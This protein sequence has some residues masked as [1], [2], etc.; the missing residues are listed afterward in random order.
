MT[1]AIPVPLTTFSLV[2][3][4]V[5]LALP[6]GRAASS[7]GVLEVDR[8]DDE[9]NATACTPAPDDCSFRGAAINANQTPGANTIEMPAGI[10]TL[11]ISGPDEDA[12]ANSDID[13]TDD[14]ALK[15]AGIGKT[16]IDGGLLDTVLQIDANFDGATA[17]IEDLTIRNGRAGVRTSGDLTLERTEITG[18]Q[19][20]GL[21]VESAVVSIVDSTISGNGTIDSTNGGGVY[22]TGQ[23]ILTIEDSVI[24]GNSAT[25]G[26]A[27]YLTTPL[28]SSL[29]VSNTT[30]SDNVAESSGGGLYFT[31]GNT[32][33]TIENS[34]ITGNSARTGGAI[35]NTGGG[36]SVQVTNSTFGQNSV[37]GLNAR[38]GV[39]Y[40][41]TNSN[42]VTFT[43]VTM[44][45]NTGPLG[46]A[47][48]VSGSGVTV[49]NSIVVGTAGDNCGGDSIQ[50]D[51]H[52]LVDASGC[53]FQGAVN[54]PGEAALAPL[55]MYG[56]TTA[57]Y[58]LDPASGA[59]DAA[60]ECPPP[61]TDQRGE[62][63]PLG[64]A[65]D[66]GAV[67]G[68]LQ[69]SARLWGDNL[70]N[71]AL[72]PNDA[73]GVLFFAS[74]VDPETAVTGVQGASDCP[75]VGQGVYVSDWDSYA[76]GDVNCDGVVD[77]YDA[78][79]LLVFVALGTPPDAVCPEL[80]QEVQLLLSS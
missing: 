53:S 46:A 67:E 24:S 65:C 35:Y 3:V 55:G 23:S 11:T 38:G 29:H 80:G 27:I 28:G 12:A 44:A 4:A 64:P 69:A 63:R 21:R 70:C 58:G 49:V 37:S 14:L 76:W 40:Q 33:I 77:G 79:I 57:T 74:G 56:G 62:P 68:A 34:A 45:E 22:V 66:I 78:L 1:K 13:V 31:S 15:G 50:G 26:G 47:I 39:L 32:P 54:V 25:S 61:A 6:G 75:V 30:I 19:G 17:A 42:P 8:T 18:N 36:A 59:I 20:N 10:Y 43:H 7:S 52:N 9:L 71:G 51:G 41:T 48:H 60:P 72:D 5:L 73:A 2:F 16:I